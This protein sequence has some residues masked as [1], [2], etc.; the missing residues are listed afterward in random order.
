MPVPAAEPPTTTE[1]LLDAE[2]AAAL[3]H[4]TVSHLEKLRRCA[5]LPAID[6]SVPSAAARRRGMYRYLAADLIEWARSRNGSG[7]V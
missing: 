3:L 4:C 5:G 2:G 7:C 6:I 1:T